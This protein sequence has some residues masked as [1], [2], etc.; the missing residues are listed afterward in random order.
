MIPTAYEFRSDFVYLY[1]LGDSM[2]ARRGCSRTVRPWPDF[3]WELG[4]CRRLL[5]VW[6]WSL[7]GLG[8]LFGWKKALEA[9]EG[10]L[11]GLSFW[12]DKR[13]SLTL[14]TKD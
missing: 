2:D 10:S 14:G 12:S 11:V 1:L 4:S 7:K 13:G 9:G 6:G 5:L 3:T 8:F